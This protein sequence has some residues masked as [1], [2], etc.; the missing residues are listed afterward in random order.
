MSKLLIETLPPKI[1]NGKSRQYCLVQCPDCHKKREIRLD[2][3]K[4]AETTCCRSCTNLRRPTKPEDELF[5]WKAYYRS[6]E[7]KLAHTF[8]T[9]RLRCKE[10]GWALPEYT[11]E[12][13]IA[14]GMSLPEYHSIFDAWVFSGFAKHLSPSVDRLDDYKTYSFSNIRMVPWHQNNDKGRHWQVIGKNTK[15]CL[16]VDQLTMGGDFIKRFH[17]IK[18]ASRELKID[19]SKISAV[20]RGIPIKKG[21]RTSLPI[22]AG[23]FK[24]RYS[25]IPN[26]ITR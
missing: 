26:P 21:N 2:V 25:T 1:T 4:Q 5:D 18:A 19:D 23:G 22:S 6:K 16:A 14:W 20:C 9:Q 15:N 17:S 3:F 24:W 8:Q 13:F 12:E 7:G 11:R 10:K